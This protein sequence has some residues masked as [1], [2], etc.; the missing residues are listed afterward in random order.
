[1]LTAA[2]IKDA[3]VLTEE[4]IPQ[5]VVHRSSQVEV[6]ENNLKPLL[7]G[8]KG[9]NMLIYGP[10]GVG[11][12]CV[13]RYV[14]QELSSHVPDLKQSFVNCWTKDSNFKILYE[15]VQDLGSPLGLHRKGISTDDL[16]NKLEAIEQKHKKC[17]LVL[18]EVD[19]LEDDKLLYRLSQLPHLTLIFLANS[20]TVF[21]D[22]DPRVRSRLEGKD[23]LKFPKYSDAE[24]EDILSDRAK[25]GLMPDALDRGQLKRIAI[26]SKGDARKGITCL[27]IAAEAAEQEDETIKDEHIRQALPR[28][29]EE[30]KQDSVASL[31]PHQQI[32]Y[33]IIEEEKEVKPSK[34]YKRYEAEREGDRVVRRTVRKYLKKMERYELIEK[35]G[36]G[37]WTSYQLAD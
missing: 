14:L 11:K 20:E 3:R 8:N 27:R 23:D 37:R 36:E 33:Q 13:T 5:E 1:M 17:V 25:W 7:E 28:A 22:A 26:A 31:N 15:V 32:L 24:L 16:L 18:D 29:E 6:I 4:F 2:V 21:Y 35:K 9:R 34:L 19:Q 12:T 30:K 10:T